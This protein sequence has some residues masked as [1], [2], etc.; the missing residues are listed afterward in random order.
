[1]KQKNF[2]KALLFL[3]FLITSN[4]SFAQATIYSEDFTGQNNKGAVGPTP[5]TDLTGVNWT[6]DIT[7]ATLSATSDWFQVVNEVFEARDIDGNAIWMSPSIDISGHTNISFSLLAEE[8]GTMEGSD[9]FN[10]EYRINGNAGTWTAA[11]TNGTLSD[12]FTSATVSQTGLNGNTL[13]IRVTM[14]NGAGEEYHR[15]D[16]ILV[17]GTVASTDPSVTFDSATSAVNETDT[18]VIT[19]GIPI[20]LTNYDADVTITA[21]V[22]G[23][24]TAEAGDY[25]LDLTPLTF[26]ANETLVLPLTIKDDADSDDETIIIDFTVTSGTA[27]LGI[28]THTV[29]IT[30]DELPNL[31]INEF[32][33][34]PDATNGDA[35][36]DSTVNSSDDEFIEIYNASGG[37][38]NIGDY[39]IEDSV[40]LRHTFPK[41][42][43]LPTAGT[44]VVF[45]GGT[46]TNIPSLTQ[47]ASVGFLGLNNGGDTITIK[48]AGGTTVTSYTYGAEGGNNIALARNPDLTGSFVTHD[49]VT[50]NGAVLFSPG[51]D[52]TDNTGF[53]NTWSGTTN[54]DWSTATNWIDS[55]NPSAASDNVYI[56]GG[57]TNYPTASSAVTK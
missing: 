6:I 10:T 46:P 51:R 1:M 5:T 55:D 7:N 52:N 47:T 31:V 33:A 8:V 24:S 41:G 23:S 49:N 14:N 35:N 27:D 25:T 45:G 3:T 42:T 32:L 40:G 12:D 34:D 11:T 37:E 18:D 39:T 26:D 22:N 2:F 21:T 20:T 44:I 16:D 4:Y 28:S 38:L 50:G 9:I 56:P 36:G 53:Y 19:S 48:D 15:L 57:L 13:E 29:T 17:Q 54:N 43:I 30:D